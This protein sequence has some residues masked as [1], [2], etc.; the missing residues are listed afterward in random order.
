MASS[1]LL[2]LAFAECQKKTSTTQLVALKLKSLLDATSRSPQFSFAHGLINEL[3]KSFLNALSE[4]LNAP[5]HQVE[6]SNIALLNS[7]SLP[8]FQ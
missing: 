1:P 4:G 2:A 3:G 6:A 5:A 7:L 8:I